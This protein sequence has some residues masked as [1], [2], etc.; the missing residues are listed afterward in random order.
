VHP[1]ASL[2]PALRNPER[3]QLEPE[4]SY[5]LLSDAT[6]NRC[7]PLI[8]SA[9]VATFTYSARNERPDSTDPGGA[10]ANELP[11]ASTLLG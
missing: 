3:V 6:G 1:H 9:G 4:H 11:A 2:L 7:S 8:A 5:Q 10:L